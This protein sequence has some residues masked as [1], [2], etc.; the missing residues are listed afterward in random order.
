MILKY[1]TFSMQI[2]CLTSLLN[3]SDPAKILREQNGFIIYELMQIVSNFR[4]D[5]LIL[6]A[7]CKLTTK[8]LQLEAVK[9]NK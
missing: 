2:E 5:P 1:K 7:I 3:S 9:N 4:T 8:V 6:T